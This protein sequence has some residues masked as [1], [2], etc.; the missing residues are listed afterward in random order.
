MPLYSAL[1]LFSVAIPFALSFD[2]KLQFYKQ[3]KFLFPAIIVVA[4]FFIAID[5]YFTKLGVW[6]FNSRYHSDIKLFGLPIEEWLFF[7]AIPYASIFLHDA[8]ILYFKS[9]RLIN[10]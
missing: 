4:L 10:R 8:V 6:G 2:R 1:L 9:F 3:W 5:I 7:I